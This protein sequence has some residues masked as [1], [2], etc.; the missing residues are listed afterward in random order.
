MCGRFADVPSPCG[1]R[2]CYWAWCKYC[3]ARLSRRNFWAR[4]GPGLVNSYCIARYM[5]RKRIL[6]IL[7]QRPKCWFL[8]CSS[9]HPF[10]IIC[11]N[12]FRLDLQMLVGQRASNHVLR[13]P[14]PLRGAVCR[15][16]RRYELAANNLRAE[17]RPRRPPGL[18]AAMLGLLNIGVAVVQ[19]NHLAGPL[20]GALDVLAGGLV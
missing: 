19:P 1:G 18:L 4:L 6:P 12:Q 5:L 2:T 8:S 11:N 17:K 10:P 14:P 3:F 15:G 7:C 16:A 13:R 9:L 20:A